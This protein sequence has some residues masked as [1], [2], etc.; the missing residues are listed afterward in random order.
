[1]KTLYVC[2]GRCVL[3]MTIN[4]KRTEKVNTRGYHCLNFSLQMVSSNH[5][6]SSL[7]ITDVHGKQC[8]REVEMNANEIRMFAAATEVQDAWTPRLCDRVCLK[9]DIYDD[10]EDYLG[11]WAFA[12][13]VNAGIRG[14]YAWLPYQHQL[15]EIL[16]EH[17]DMPPASI[18]EDVHEFL[19]PEMLCSD[20]WICSR[21]AGLGEYRRKTFRSMDTVML[22]V[23]MDIVYS[24]FWWD[25][26]WHI[27]T[28]TR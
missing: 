6:H 1:M 26:D 13:S 23:M 16:Q 7:N 25:G 11:R 21:C 4:T 27:R 28:P 2:C 3:R 12:S 15:Q 8:C 24:K 18:A 17:H 5:P 20:E 9:S 19:S 10:A 14:R 22:G